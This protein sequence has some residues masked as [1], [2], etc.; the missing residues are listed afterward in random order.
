MCLPFQATDCWVSVLSLQSSDG[1]LLDPDDRLSDVA[2][3]REQIVAVFE[4]RDGRSALYRGGD[5]TS[6]SSDGTRSP[7]QFTVSRGGVRTPS[8]RH[9][10]RNCYTDT[11]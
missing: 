4:E 7:V 11:I 1:G 2:D 3:D 10:L 5:G 6:A 8:H 9:R